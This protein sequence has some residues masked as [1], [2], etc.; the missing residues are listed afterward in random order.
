MRL[1]RQN[2]GVY[3]QKENDTVGV[4]GTVFHLIRPTVY[5]FVV[6]IFCLLLLPLWGSVIVLCFVVR[7]FMSILVLQSS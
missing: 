2:I 3:S 5:I 1:G 7:Y 6:D 4:C